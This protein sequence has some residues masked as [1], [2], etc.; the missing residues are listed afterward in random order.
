[1]K[2][3][4]RMFGEV[5]VGDGE[6]VFMD[7]GTHGVPGHTA[8]VAP[9]G[10]MR[11]ERRVDSMGE[12]R[13]T[14]EGSLCLDDRERA[15]LG[16]WAEAAFRLGDPGRPWPPPVPAEGPPSRPPEPPRYCWVVLLRRGAAIRAVEG[17]NWTGE[18]EE[19]VP[20]MRWLVERVDRACEQ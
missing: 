18:P 10:T 6:L 4:T 5:E 19:L 12:D 3:K 2:R 16:G 14:G 13:N 8:R 1:M 20:M 17:D 9:D 11:W 7:G 15:R